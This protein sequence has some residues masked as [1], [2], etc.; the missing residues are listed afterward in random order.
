MKNK[1]GP[2]AV[3]T[4]IL[5]L[6]LAACGQQQAGAPAGDSLPGSAL[7][8]TTWTMTSMAKTKTLP[9]AEITAGF[10]GGDMSGSTGCNNYFAAYQTNGD[11]LTLEGGGVTEMACLAP[12]GVM[13]QETRFLDYWNQ[14]ERFHLS[15]EQLTLFTRAGEQLI[16]V[17][18]P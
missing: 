8:N 14:V 4:L 3:L 2:T 15:A 11:R 18:R 5:I 7:E 17:P 9:G 10:I 16:F 1:I 6:L 12:D 13:E